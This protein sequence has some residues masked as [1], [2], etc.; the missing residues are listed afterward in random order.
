VK[1][2]VGAATDVGRARERNEDSFLTAPPLFAVA[3][4]MGGH[5]GGNVAS[6]IAVGVLSDIAQDGRWPEMPDQFRAANRAILDRSR[7]DRNLAGMGTTLTAGFMEG[8][9]IHF[10]H[11]GDTRAYLLR[12]GQFTTLTEDHTLVHEMEKQGRITK[13]EAETHPQRSILIRALGVDDPL[14]VDESSLEAREGDR[15]LLCSDG[16]HSMVSDR[17]IEDVLETTPDPQEAANRLIDMAN[18]AGGL[19]NIT[20]MI[21]DFEPGDGVEGTIVAPPN[22]QDIDRGGTAEMPVMTP[23]QPD[24]TDITVARPIPVIPPA[25]GPESAGAAASPAPGV[26]TATQP[27]QAPPRPAPPTAPAAPAGSLQPRG[28]RR[29]RLVVAGVVLLGLAVGLIG[30]RLWLDTRWYVGVHEVEGEERV[31]VFR[32]MPTVIFGIRLDGLV[33]DEFDQT[34]ITLDELAR[35]PEARLWIVKLRE[36]VTVGSQEEA[37]RTVDQIRTDLEGGDQGGTSPPG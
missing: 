4:G 36:G 30:A 20:V 22:V 1:V 3:D 14:Q 35:V 26:A 19:D 11:V 12:D 8:A 17:A 9:L 15:L 23:V 34:T 7:A 28:R 29:W 2:R 6:S 31:A 18:Q 32:G 27:P 33:A 5:R 13:E 25:G 24:R 16:L 21:L 37:E 10:A